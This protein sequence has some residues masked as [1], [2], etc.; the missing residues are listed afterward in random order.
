MNPYIR[1][2]QKLFFQSLWV[3]EDEEKKFNFY[4]NI[5]AFAQASNKVAAIGKAKTAVCEVDTSI[6][7]QVLCSLESSKDEDT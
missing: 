4:K 7:Q 2:I 3:D 1:G 6:G 5:P